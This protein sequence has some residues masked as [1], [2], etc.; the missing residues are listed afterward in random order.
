MVQIRMRLLL[1]A[2]GVLLFFPVLLIAQQTTAESIPEKSASLAEVVVTAQK[3]EERLQDVPVPVTAISASALLETNQVDIKDYYTSVPGLSLVPGTT[4]GSLGTQITIRGLSA[5]GGNP[6]V[7]IVVDDVPF[8]GSTTLGAGGVVPDFDPSDL[9]SIEVLRGPQGTLYGANSLGGLLKYV[10]VDPSTDAFG[11]RIQAGVSSVYNGDQVGYNVRA[12]ANIPIDSTLAIRLSGF[13]RRDPGYID[14]IQSGQR[15]V[16]R[17]EAE[18]G[19]L[20]TLWRPSEDFSLKFSAQLQDTKIYGFP[21]VDRGLGDLQQSDLRGTGVYDDKFQA[22]TLTA[23]GKLG[24]AELTSLSGFTV[25]NSSGFQDYTF[26]FGAPTK[27]VFGVGGDALAN[28]SDA[29]NFSQEVRL[30]MPIAARVDWL[31]GAFFTHQHSSLG[32]DLRAVDQATGDFVGQWLW[33]PTIT[34]YQ[35]YAVFTDFTVHFTDQFDVQLGGRGSKITQDYVTSWTGPFVTDILKQANPLL[36]PRQETQNSTFT[37]LVTPQYKFSPDL[38]LYARLASGYRPGGPNSD[39]GINKLPTYNPDK[40]ENYEIGF[41]GDVL[42]HVLSFDASVYYIDWSDIQILVVDPATHAGIFVNGSRA[43]SQG[44]E[45][46]VESHPFS[47][48]TLAG[49]IASNDAELTQNLPIG[50]AGTAVGSAGNQLPVSSRFSGNVSL[51]E[52]FPISTDVAGFV[53]GSVSYVG[54]RMGNFQR[55]TVARQIFPAYAQTDL[56]GG[57]R[58]GFWTFDVFATNVTDKRG[59][60]P[61]ASP[62]LSA[63]YPIQPRTVGVNVSRTF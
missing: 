24:N 37:Y 42:D 46:S 39:S 16:N 11:G 2:S 55:A 13:V 12:A 35:E 1:Q 6:T 56:R 54:E 50:L 38:M 29:R 5:G 26:A 48:L 45:L 61:S 33:E 34:S 36:P 44:V 9:S 51:R 18:G 62:N 32:T 63:E 60:L 7:G 10:T 8:G 58:D 49:W 15:D 31:L 43:K 28:P 40:T 53:G 4:G 14:N 19:R 17:T 20:S 3:R 52:E 30:S 41:K 47:G 57:V 23:R 22:Y 27:A 21:Y 25:Y 59:L